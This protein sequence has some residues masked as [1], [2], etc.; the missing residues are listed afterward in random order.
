MDRG[1]EVVG[2]RAEIIGL[3][4]RVIE[5]RVTRP[6]KRTKATPPK[7]RPRWRRVRAAVSMGGIDGWLKDAGR[8]ESEAITD[9][10]GR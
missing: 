10:D 6:E 7:K 2:V 8:L 5:R 1:V 3:L 9:A 4:R